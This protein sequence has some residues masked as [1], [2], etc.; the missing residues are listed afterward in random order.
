MAIATGC[1][2]AAQE[3]P[4]S[5]KSSHG[6]ILLD[7]WY[8]S[9]TRPGADGKPELYHYK[10]DDTTAS[11]YSLFGQMWRDAGVATETLT[12]EPTAAALKGAQY[13][14]I[15]SPDNPAKNQHP[16]FMTE[17]DA[18]AIEQWVGAGGV[19]LMMENDPANADIAHLD[20][21]ADKFGLHFNNVLVHHVVGDDFPAG[22]I[23]VGAKAP[24]TH[25]H[26][27]YMK[28]TCSLALSG[29]TVPLIVWKGDTL[30]GW[31]RFGRGIVVAVT[32]PWL[33]NEYTDGKKL[34]SFYDQQA[35]G[36]EFV[37][38]VIEQRKAGRR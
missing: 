3:Q 37:R 30:M 15:V 23:N 1:A 13:Y 9:Q 6:T 7:A 5:L 28:D 14:V 10:W 19:L 33:Y 21:L 31:T 29:K 4:P 36:R 25:P 17:A 34:P 27:I 32:D 24:F 16:H 18:A 11:G 26:T 38:W 35:A 2:A 12:T 8:N 22:R 20:L